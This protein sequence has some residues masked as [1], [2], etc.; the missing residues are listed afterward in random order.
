MRHKEGFFTFLKHR[1]PNMSEAED[2]QI[3]LYE[4]KFLIKDSIGFVS[5]LIDYIEEYPEASTE[6]VSHYCHDSVVIRDYRPLPGKW[7]ILF[8]WCE[9]GDG[10]FFYDFRD[11]KEQK[12]RL[13]WW[14]ES[15]V[16][17]KR[18]QRRKAGM[19]F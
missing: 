1:L 18:I 2:K 14:P 13:G 12:A 19:I 4:N 5:S 7:Y 8:G 6:Y 3:H 11:L 15:R 9:I 16:Q 10:Y 17:K